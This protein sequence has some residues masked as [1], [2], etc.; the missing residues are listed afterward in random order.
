MTDKD[1]QR[2]N[3]EPGPSPPNS[4]IAPPPRRPT[5]LYWNESL[6]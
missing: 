3:R 2:K 4:A 1:Y 5:P 6:D